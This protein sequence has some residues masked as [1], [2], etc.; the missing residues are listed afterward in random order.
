MRFYLNGKEKIIIVDDYIPVV[1]DGSAA[2]CRSKVG[3]E[4]WMSL[5]E[6]GWAKLHG[7]YSAIESGQAELVF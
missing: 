7:S 3:G 2:F 1:N 6:K 5:V 4:M